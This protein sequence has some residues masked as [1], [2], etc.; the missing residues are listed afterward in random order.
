MTKDKHKKLLVFHPLIAPYRLDLF[1]DI[2]TRWNASIYLVYRRYWRFKN[3]DK[4]VRSKFKFEPRY[5][6]PE[7]K[8]KS[9]GHFSLRYWKIIRKE[10]PDYVFVWEFGT[11]TLLTILYKYFFVKNFKIITFCDDSPAML[12]QCTFK[13]RIARNFLS[14][15]VDN[16]I[17]ASSLTVK[18]F[19]EKFNKGVYFPI[20]K[21][22]GIA[23]KYLYDENINEDSSLLAEK[24]SIR[25]KNIFLFVGRLDAEKNVMTLIR[26]FSRMYNK[27]EDVLLIVGT[28]SKEQEY[29]SF[30]QQNN[31]KNIL[32]L[33]RKE[34]RELISIYNL[35]DIFILPSSYEPFGAV[36]NEALV[37]GCFTIVSNK[38]GSNC[39]IENGKNGFVFSPNSED[40]LCWL[41]IQ[42]KD[43]I[44]HTQNYLPKPNLM[45]ET[46]KD[47]F[48]KLTI[49]LFN[50]K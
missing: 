14:K 31:I 32:L 20:I 43:K 4:D 38:A 23:R 49:T 13:H 35:A 39:L 22:D 44:R 36:T 3:Y 27:E 33:G 41:L 29:K 30:V 25:Q 6:Y 47:L 19:N 2:A 42:A 50:E 15:F 46:Y 8:E 11:I 7:G 48:N 9:S 45:L 26:A 34:G 28:G 10:N 5:I 16:A 17:L 18:W 24:L 21:D 1:N 37:Y 12:S 40:E